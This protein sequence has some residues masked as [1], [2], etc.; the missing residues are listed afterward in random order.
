MWPN[1][2]GNA[3]IDSR[4]SA[5]VTRRL[6]GLQR[7]RMAETQVMDQRVRR[8]LHDEV[9]Q[10]LHAAILNLANKEGS[11]EAIEMMTEV[12]GEISRLISNLPGTSVPDLAG[13]GLIESL[14]Q[15]VEDEVGQ[16]F[17]NVTWEMSSRGG[18]GR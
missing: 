14:K 17:D 4:V 8:V 15:L 2:V 3:S 6:L 13:I 7:Q 18:Y 16:G 9:L 11:E 5:E 1:P 10:D 12:H